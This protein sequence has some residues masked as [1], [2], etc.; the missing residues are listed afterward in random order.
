MTTD[1]HVLLV[2]TDAIITNRIVRPNLQISILVEEEVN[3]KDFPGEC[4]LY[5]VNFADINA[6]LKIASEI[7][8]NQPIDAVLSFNEDRVSLAARIV[9]LLE[10]FGNTSSSVESVVD[11]YKMRVLLNKRPQFATVKNQFLQDRVNSLMYPVN[12][13]SR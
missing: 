3:R 5:V 13:P 12:F 9:D 10:V 11:K 2:G 7:H 4:K 1:Y 6:C 8:M